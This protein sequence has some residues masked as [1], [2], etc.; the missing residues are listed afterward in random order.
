ML[1]YLLRFLPVLG[2]LVLQKPQL[3]QLLQQGQRD[4]LIRL[5]PFVQGDHL[6]LQGQNFQDFQ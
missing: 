6:A 2:C 1:R 3:G 4:L 5:H